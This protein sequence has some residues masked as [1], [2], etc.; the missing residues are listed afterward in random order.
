[1]HAAGITFDE[2]TWD[3]SWTSRDGADRTPMIPSHEV[4]GTVAA[5]GSGRHWRG[6]GGRG[7][8]P[9]RLRPGR[10]GRRIRNGARQRAR[11][12]AAISLACAGRDAAA[13]RADRVAGAGRPRGPGARRARAGARR[14]GRRRRLRGPARRGSRRPGHRDRAQPERGLRPGPR[15]Q[16]FI[17]ARARAGERRRTRTWSSTRSAAGRWRTASR[18]CAVAAA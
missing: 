1:M 3:L 6:A 13:G 12:P 7:L 8:C 15:R 4:S 5:T 17:S 2:L 14:R 11:R 16:E 9:H 10:R 18:C